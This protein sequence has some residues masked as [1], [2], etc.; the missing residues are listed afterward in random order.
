MEFIE[1]KDINELVNPGVISRQL[2][3]PE[4]SSSQRVTI[5]GCLMTGK[6]SLYMFP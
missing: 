2:L 4:N 3:N 6:A 1:K 5:T